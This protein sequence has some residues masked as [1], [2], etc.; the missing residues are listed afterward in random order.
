MPASQ[1]SQ[2]ARAAESVAPKPVVAV[3]G[4][5]PGSARSPMSMVTRTCGLT[6]RSTGSCPEARVTSASCTRA[7][8]SRWAR[9]RRSPAG[10]SACTT[11]SR[12]A[13]SFSPPTADRHAAV[14]QPGHR[15]RPALGRV[16]FGA[17]G[18]QPGQVVGHHPTQLDVL[19]GGGGLGQ[20]GVH[21][22]QLDA[23]LDRFRVRLVTS[24]RGD[25]RHL[26]GGHRAVGER[27]RQLRQLVQRA[28]VADQ[29]AHRTG[30]EPH[31]PAQPGGHRGQPVVLGGL[32][33]LAAAHRAGELGVDPVRRPDQLRRP[34]QQLGSHQAVEVLGGQGV[35]GRLQLAHDT[36]PDLR[37]SCIS[38]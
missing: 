7:S 10:R 32:G 38:A 35:E 18:V 36:S 26:L 14:Q 24:H 2:R 4:L 29:P 22:G 30:G 13:H 34:V 3:A 25:H 31:V 20:H 15:Q 17:V 27:R 16:R 8:P 5:V 19:A 1:A 6:V 12:A 23:L 9:V 28:A 37:T 21:R 11:D 33:D